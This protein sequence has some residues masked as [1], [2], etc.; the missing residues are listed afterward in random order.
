[1]FVVRDGMD[2]QAKLEPV[3]RAIEVGELVVVPTDTVYGLAALADDEHAVAR[4][5]AC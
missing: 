5:Y 4:M 1:M 3:L 2:G